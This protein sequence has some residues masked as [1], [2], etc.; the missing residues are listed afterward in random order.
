MTF[1]SNDKRSHSQAELHTPSPSQRKKQDGRDTPRGAA[2]PSIYRGPK[3]IYPS[4]HDKHDLINVVEKFTMMTMEPD[5]ASVTKDRTD[6]FSNGETL[7]IKL[8]E[9]KMIIINGLEKM[10]V[11]AMIAESGADFNLDSIAIE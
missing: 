11:K 1:G 4:R 9:Q 10:L 6:E 7:V 5:M 8:E 3:P 2:G